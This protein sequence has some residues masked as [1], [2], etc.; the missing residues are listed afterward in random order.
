MCES[1]LGH[2]RALCVC[3]GLQFSVNGEFILVSLGAFGP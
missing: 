2:P 3:D 1:R